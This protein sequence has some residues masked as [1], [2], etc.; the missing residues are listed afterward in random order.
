[1]SEGKDSPASAEGPDDPNNEHHLNPRPASG[2]YELPCGYVDSDGEL[3]THV[4]VNELTGVEEELLAGRGE[5]LFRMNKVMANA[6]QNVGPHPATM[7]IIHKL[8]VVDRYF[9]LIALRRASLG[10]RYE[11]EV[12]C[13]SC[14][15]KHRRHADLGSLPI[16]PMA[17]P[18][19]RNV[20]GTTPNGAEFTLHVMTGKDEL[21][22][23]KAK[24]KLDGHGL[25]TLNMICRM[26]SFDGVEICRDIKSKQEFLSSVNRIARL[27]L[28]DRNAI[29]QVIDEAEGD[30]DLNLEFSCDEC[31]EDWE[32]E[33]DLSSRDFFFPSAT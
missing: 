4:I 6:V 14:K 28:R 29:R 22:L 13:P 19:K 15:V 23:S 3:H 24:K 30:I 10:D 18:K 31:G 21:W 7:G 1:M 17:D 9:L 8:T 33:L 2:S 27:G 16:T 26:D 11:V 20:T 32:R 5:I 25:I 12:V